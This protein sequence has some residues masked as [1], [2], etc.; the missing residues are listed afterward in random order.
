MSA[1]HEA[2]R[3]YLGCPFQHQGRSRRGLD[4]VGLVVM[5]L[6][7]CGRPVEDITTYGREPHSGLLESHLL[8]AFGPAIH[9]DEMQ[10]GDIVA[11]DFAGAVRHVG[12]TGDYPYGGLSLIHTDQ[13]LGQVIEHRLDAKWAARIKGV[14]RP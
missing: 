6:A 4:C 12:I 3:A 10:P 13:S 9:R 14:W 2:A 11:I 7:D 8:R 1:L 5:C